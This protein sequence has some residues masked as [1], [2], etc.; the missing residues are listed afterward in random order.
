[1]DSITCD[2]L[3]KKRHIVYSQQKVEGQKVR[4]NF[5]TTSKSQLTA[6]EFEF[7]VVKKD[8][9]PIVGGY[10]MTGLLGLSTSRS[11]TKTFAESFD[12]KIYGHLFMDWLYDEEQISKNRFSILMAYDPE[13]E[14]SLT[15]GSVPDNIDTVL[16]KSAVSHRVAG[17]DHWSL[18]LLDIRVGD[19]SIKP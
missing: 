17:D 12:P 3:G 2:W 4:D 5:L 15:F 16:L 9:A 14:S 13:Q 8:H 11:P 10:E 19:K 18:K 6:S 1:M 7:L